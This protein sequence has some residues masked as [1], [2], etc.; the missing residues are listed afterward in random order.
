MN[1][2]NTGSNVVIGDETRN[3]NYI[4]SSDDVNI[5]IEN[6][7]LLNSGVDKTL[8]K[9]TR[10][11]PFLRITGRRTERRRPLEKTGRTEVR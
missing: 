2:E 10:Q 4:T 11:K 3:D 1:V 8:I 6:G 7:S 9:T 5:N